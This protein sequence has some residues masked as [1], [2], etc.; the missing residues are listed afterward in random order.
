M[1][2]IQEVS[3]PGWG[4]TSAMKKHHKNDPEGTKSKKEPTKKTEF[5]DKPKK[6]KKTKF[7][8]WLINLTNETT[9]NYDREQFVKLPWNWQAM[10][11]SKIVNPL[12]Y[13]TK[14]EPEEL[15]DFQFSLITLPNLQSI[16]PDELSAKNRNT[17]YA[18]S[19]DEFL[20]YLQNSQVWYDRKID[21]VYDG[22][23]KIGKQPED[24]GGKDIRTNSGRFKEWLE[25]RDPEI[26][27]EGKR[28]RKKTRTIGFLNGSFAIP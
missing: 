18:P 5:K 17:G 28:K 19:S 26:I 3:P 16:S 1:E 27:E 10:Q 9:T 11:Q 23:K 15:Q 14:D 6:K 13:Y 4:G 12:Y 25:Q 20:K 24:F 21:Q 8:E 7:K 2:K 22:I